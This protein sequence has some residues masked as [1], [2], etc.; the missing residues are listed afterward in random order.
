MVRVRVRVR[1]QDPRGPVFEAEVEGD[2]R[3]DV[4]EPTHR[5]EDGGL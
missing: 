1:V 3:N 4:L 5:E 2:A